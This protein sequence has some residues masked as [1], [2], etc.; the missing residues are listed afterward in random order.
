MDTLVVVAKKNSSLS[1]T[2]NKQSAGTVFTTFQFLYNLQ[3]TSIKDRLHWRSLLA[4]TLA[5]ATLDCT[6][7]GHLGRHDTDRIVSIGQGK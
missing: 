5:R 7:L 1:N 6:C 4:N 3:M 2:G